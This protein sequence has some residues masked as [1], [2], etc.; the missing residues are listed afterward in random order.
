MLSAGAL[1]SS[2]ILQRSGLGGGRAGQGLAFNMASPVTFDFEQEL[3][4]ERGLQIT[5]YMEPADPTSHEGLAFET[6][7][8]PI[9]SQSLFMPGW[10]EEHWDNMRRYPHMTCLGVVVGTGVRRHRSRPTRCGGMKFD[11]MP[12][13]ERLRAAQE[14]PAA[15]VRDRARGRRR[16]G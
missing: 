7:F 5:H 14:G 15:R 6:W 9:V 3:H 1:A 8:N 10:F 16:S 2:V 4:S 12:S 13:D 11:Y